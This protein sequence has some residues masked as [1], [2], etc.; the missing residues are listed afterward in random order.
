[1]S[2][3]KIE[4]SIQNFS[5]IQ[6]VLGCSSH[7]YLTMTAILNRMQLMVHQQRII[8]INS[9]AINNCNIIYSPA[10]LHQKMNR[11]LPAQTSL[12]CPLSNSRKDQTNIVP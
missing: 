12:F 9:L 2:T 7:L 1:M 8:G 10:G 4:N 5:K 11:Y 6:N 3:F